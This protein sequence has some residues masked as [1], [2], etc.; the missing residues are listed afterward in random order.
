MRRLLP[1][2]HDL[3]A[4][5]RPL[6]RRDRPPARLRTRAPRLLLRDPVG[7]TYKLGSDVDDGHHPRHYFPGDERWPR[8]QVGALDQ[9]SFADGS[10]HLC[11]RL[12]A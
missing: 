7:H 10:W 8:T 1:R 11:P 5:V 9:V 12:F 2:N 3:P 6:P 4:G